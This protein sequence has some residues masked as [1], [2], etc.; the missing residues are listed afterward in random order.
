[1]SD[2]QRKKNANWVVADKAGNSLGVEH[3]QIAVLMDIRD[4]LQKL[5]N[6]LHCSNFVGIPATLKSIR[7][8]LP[9]PQAAK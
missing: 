3:A 9:T 7:R 1:M 6:L 5:N 2:L 4:E 8:K